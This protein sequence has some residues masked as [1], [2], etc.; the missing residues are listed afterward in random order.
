MQR[1]LFAASKIMASGKRSAGAAAASLG[2]GKNWQHARRGERRR[3]ALVMRRNLPTACG[4]PGGLGNHF[5]REIR[6]NENGGK[7]GGAWLKT[8]AAAKS[9][10]WRRSAAAAGIMAAS[11]AAGE[12]G[13]E[14]S[15]RPA[16]WRK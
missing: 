15:A 5:A 16:A 8:A 2:G 13:G 10:A 4:R 11:A 9:I 14:I 1:R 3:L 12:N 7:L 6:R